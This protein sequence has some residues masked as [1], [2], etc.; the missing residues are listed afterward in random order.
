MRCKHIW[1][2]AINVQVRKTLLTLL[3]IKRARPLSIPR[4]VA[5]QCEVLAGALYQAGQILIYLKAAIA[6]CPTS[7]VPSASLAATAAAY[8]ALE[9]KLNECN[10]H[11]GTLQTAPNCSD[12]TMS[13]GLVARG[14]VP[15]DQV[16]VLPMVHDKAIADNLAAPSHT[17]PDGGCVK[18]Y[19]WR[20]AIPGD[21]V[22]VTPQTRA[23]TRA[24]NRGT[25]SQVQQPVA[26]SPGQLT[27]PSPLELRDGKCSAVQVPS[28]ISRAQPLRYARCCAA[29]SIQKQDHQVSRPHKSAPD[30]AGAHTHL[31]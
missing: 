20:E 25:S 6:S 14:A 7:P 27:C 24:D 16:C 29:A 30:Q 17:N 26:Q 3:V 22:C 12:P 19:V 21:H 10:K 28:V 4:G 23:Q 1:T 11:V 9:A 13:G 15:G 5:Q 2:S 8:N 18:G 31:P